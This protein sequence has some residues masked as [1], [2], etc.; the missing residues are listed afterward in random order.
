MIVYLSIFVPQEHSKE[1]WS[2]LFSLSMSTMCLDFCFF[3]FS[4]SHGW[5]WELDHKEC[6]R[7][8]DL[9]CGARASSWE[10]FRQQGD[11]TSQSN[12]KS[13]LIG[14]TDVEAE[15]SILWPPDV[16]SWI[17]GKDPDAG[18][19]WGQEEKDV[20]VCFQLFTTENVCCRLIYMAF[21]MLR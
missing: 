13:T 1:K 9:N 12:R 20:T 14:R 5:M 10:S 16:Q 21:S 6:Q 18:K 4:S 11:Q 15:V 2:F 19:D 8:D 7:I 17:N 3:G